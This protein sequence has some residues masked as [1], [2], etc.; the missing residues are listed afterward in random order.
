MSVASGDNI[1]NRQSLCT[2]TLAGYLRAATTYIE[3]ATHQTIPLYNDKKSLHPLIAEVLAQRSAWREPLLKKEPLTSVLLQHMHCRI[4]YAFQQDRASFL[5]KDAALLDWIRLGV[6]TGSRL[7]EYGQSTLSGNKPSNF[8]KVPISLDAGPWS[9][10]PIAFIYS[11]FVFF[12]P[13]GVLLDHPSVLHNHTA[14]PPT[15]VHIRFRFDKSPTNFTI[16]KFNRLPGCFLCPVKACISILHR[17]IA[18]HIPHS[19]PIG[20]YR[21]SAAGGYRYINGND[22]STYMQQACKL[23]YIDPNHYARIHLTRLMAHSLR[24]TACVALHQANV[25]AEDIAFRLR[26]NVDSVKFYLRDC[27]CDIGYFLITAVYNAYK[28]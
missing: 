14:T 7:G 17:A 5:D 2:K 12:G 18:L 6:H 19:H 15:Q 13:D 25:P 8:A 27:S 20:A 11:D 4:Q 23:A 28:K 24:V 1:Q 9:G 16:R 26:W 22:M 10:T 3:E 21:C